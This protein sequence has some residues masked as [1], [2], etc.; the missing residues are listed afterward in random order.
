MLGFP[1]DAIEKAIRQT[2]KTVVAEEAKPYNERIS[3]D[4]A[5]IAK[6][7]KYQERFGDLQEWLKANP[8]IEGQ[9]LL[10][11]NAGHFTLAREFAWLQ[12]DR[13][14]AGKT[15]T[16][17]VEEAAKAAEK[18]AEARSDARTFK[19]SQTTEVRTPPVEDRK[20][21]KRDELDRLTQLAKDGYEAPLWRRT[22]GETLPKEVFPDSN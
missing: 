10:A 19:P 8:E 21:V 6:Y 20:I 4:Q 14:N 12:F 1:K 7:P 22:I 18:R 2:I 11:E 13:D 16:K 15:E 17:G 9:V 3:A 5:I